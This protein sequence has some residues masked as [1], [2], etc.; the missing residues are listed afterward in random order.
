ME[1]GS[2]SRL[3]LDDPAPSRG[4][5]FVRRVVRDP[6]RRHRRAVEQRLERHL[7]DEQT[8]AH[9]GMPVRPPASHE[10]GDE[11]VVP[12]DDDLQ[13]AHPRRGGVGHRSGR[14]AGRPHTLERCPP[15]PAAAVSGPMAA[16]NPCPTT[17]SPSRRARLRWWRP[18]AAAGSRTRWGGARPR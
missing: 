2:A 12:L 18:S 3:G 13:L 8:V 15:R 16:Q 17:T 6:L 5:T 11:T 7:R 1:P 10:V 4:L 9:R 14:G